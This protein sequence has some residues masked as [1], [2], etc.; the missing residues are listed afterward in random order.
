M[1]EKP[2]ILFL[3]ETE[4]NSI[5][6][7]RIAAKAWPGGLTT[8]VDVDGVSGGLTFICDAHTIML[9][10][11]HANKNFIQANFHI[12]GTNIHE[13]LTNVYFT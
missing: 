7:E 3:Q 1:Q 12:I 13:L 6:L 4:C 9:N 8:S 5:V 10:N 11:I 2:Q